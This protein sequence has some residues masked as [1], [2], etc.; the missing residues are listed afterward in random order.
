MNDLKSN[1]YVT[2]TIFKPMNL[3]LNVWF[4]NSCKIFV[5]K[6]PYELIYRKL[7]HEYTYVLLVEREFRP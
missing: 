6:I 5:S 2:Q 3:T 4:L 7:K 1:T